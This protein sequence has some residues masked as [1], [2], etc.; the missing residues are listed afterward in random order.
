MTRKNNYQF[1]VG[2]IVIDL[3]DLIKR[4][5]CCLNLL[6]IE[7]HCKIQVIY[8]IHILNKIHNVFY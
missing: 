6:T 4:T 7:K 8:K 3:T 5:F 2:Y 1:Y